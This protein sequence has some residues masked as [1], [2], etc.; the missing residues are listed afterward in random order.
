M[1]GAAA[2]ITQ[3]SRDRNIL[4]SQFIATYLAQGEQIQI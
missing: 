3:V 4:F 2:C 1:K